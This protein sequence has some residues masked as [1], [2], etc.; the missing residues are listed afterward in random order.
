[1]RAV[2]KFD[3]SRRYRFST[4]ATW[5]ISRDYAR[6]VP[7]AGY[8]L[9]HYITGQEEMLDVADDG[10]DDAELLRPEVLAQRDLLADILRALEPRERHILMAHFGLGRRD[11]PDSLEAI[12]DSMGLSK[13]R[14]RQIE[15]RAL[16][17]I[18]QLVRPQPPPEK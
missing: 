3:Y 5:V 12:G 7:A 13:Q 8:Q 15:T 14:V 16:R 17:K 6:T 18:R 11:K 9:E 4:Y 1:M 10:R 2:E